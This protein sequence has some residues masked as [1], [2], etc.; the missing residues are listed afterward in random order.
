MKTFHHPECPNTQVRF[1][2]CRYKL[3]A[4]APLLGNKNFQLVNGMF[5]LTNTLRCKT[6]WDWSCESDP[7]MA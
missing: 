2:K 4:N 7:C 3:S 5:S 6:F 1:D